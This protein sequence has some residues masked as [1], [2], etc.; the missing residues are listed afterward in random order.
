MFDVPD[1]KTIARLQVAEKVH[2]GAK[3][4]VILLHGYGANAY[5][6][7]SLQYEL[8]G[9]PESNWYFPDGILQLELAP[10]YSGRAWF[11]IN[12]KALEDAFQSGKPLDY[13]R[14]YPPGMDRARDRILELIASLGVESESLVLGGFSQG[15][16]LA[17]EVSLH[18]PSP[19]KALLL[20]SSTLANEE[21]WLRKAKA[22]SGYSY[23]QSH[24]AGDPI[25]PFSGAERLREGLQS[26]GWDCDWCEFRGGHEIPRSALQAASRYLQ[27]RF[28]K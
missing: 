19:P 18:L 27:R 22:F 3:A 7:W 24:G 10:G 14:I 28:H 5:D 11:P 20:F 12:E 13:S 8:T 9:L 15:S 6:L 21:E 25:L 1:L 23:F 4:S 26:A 2:D 16:M 17:L